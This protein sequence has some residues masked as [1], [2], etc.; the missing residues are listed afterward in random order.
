[1]DLVTYLYFIPPNS[2]GTIS[3]VG[4]WIKRE[5]LAQQSDSVMRGHSH[6]Y[7]NWVSF[8]DDLLQNG[9]YVVKYRHY[10]LAILAFTQHNPTCV[11]INQIYVSLRYRARGIA[12]SL[13]DHLLKSYETLPVFFY[14]HSSQD[15]L[16]FYQH[17]L[18]RDQI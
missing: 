8:R 1:M 5:F 9:A 13:I 15:A 7:Y 17:F 12:R 10:W 2:L 14:L 18:D 16:P 11:E 6:P 3:K 4:Q